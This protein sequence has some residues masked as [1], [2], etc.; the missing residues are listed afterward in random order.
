MPLSLERIPEAYAVTLVLT[1]YLLAM[2]NVGSTQQPRP[3][4]PVQ[5]WRSNAKAF[6][7]FLLLVYPLLCMPVLLAYLARYAFDSNLA[8]YVV[9]GIAAAIGAAVYWVG[10]DSALQSAERRKEQILAALSAGDGPVSG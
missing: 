6:Q 9:L 3:I 2:G 8:F 1:L 4:N 5:T 10:L 7:A